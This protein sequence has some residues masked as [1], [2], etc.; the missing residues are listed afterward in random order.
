MFH[1]NV[2]SAR[3]FMVLLFATIQEGPWEF[4]NGL[5]LLASLTPVRVLCCTFSHL[6]KAG[7]LANPSS[8]MKY[9]A[10]LYSSAATPTFWSYTVGLILQTYTLRHG[11]RLRDMLSA[12]NRAQNRANWFRGAMRDFLTAVQRGVWVLH[13]P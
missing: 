10:Q 6:S 8:I 1:C 4:K 9:S 12:L 11:V 2:C 3:S 13:H 5:S 7:I